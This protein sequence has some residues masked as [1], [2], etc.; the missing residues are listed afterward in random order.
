MKLQTASC[1]GAALLLTLL[2]SMS[3]PADEKVEMGI[4]PATKPGRYNIRLDD[5]PLL[6]VFRQMYKLANINVVASPQLISHKI[7]CN[8]EE[9]ELI[10]AFL[11]MAD[12]FGYVAKEATPGSGVYSIRGRTKEEETAISLKRFF[13]ALRKEGFTEDQAMQI[14]LRT[15]D[16]KGSADKD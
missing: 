13:D 9:V 12:M 7:T 1:L 10:P 4:T 6:D 11:S 16:T 15:L 8:L 5:V 14:L 3:A 2:C